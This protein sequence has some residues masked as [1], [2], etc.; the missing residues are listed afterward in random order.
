[1]VLFRT[2]LHDY[3][4]RARAKKPSLGEEESEEVPLIRSASTINKVWKDLVGYANDVVLRKKREK[5]PENAW[6]W[7]IKYTDV[8][9]GSLCGPVSQI[10]NVSVNPEV[11]QEYLR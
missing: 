6:R 10:T 9:Q 8:K 5:D 3:A 1:M 4:E 2:F 7:T 11:K